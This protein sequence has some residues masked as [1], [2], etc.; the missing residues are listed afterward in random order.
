MAPGKSWHIPYIPVSR[1]LSCAKYLYVVLLQPV[2]D[3]QYTRIKKLLKKV[4]ISWIPDGTHY[5]GP[6][7]L[8]LQKWVRDWW[9]PSPE[10]LLKIAD[11]AY[12]GDS[13]ND[14][15]Y[16][17]LILVDSRWKEGLENAIAA[18]WEY[19]ENG[20]GLN[21]VRVTMNIAEPLIALCEQDEDFTMAKT[22]THEIYQNNKIDLYDGRTRSTE[23][24]A[25]ALIESCGLPGSWPQYL[26]LSKEEL[27][28]VSFRTLAYSEINDLKQDVIDGY[29]G[30]E[31]IPHI[32]ISNWCGRL[33][34]RTEIRRMFYR[35]LLN[36]NEGTRD[37]PLIFVD[38]LLK[39][40]NDKPQ[41]ACARSNTPESP[42][43]F[44]AVSAGMR[45]NYWKEQ[46]FQMVP[47]KKE[48]LIRLWKDAT[49][50][51]IGDNL[52]ANNE[53]VDIWSTEYVFDFNVHK[54]FGECICQ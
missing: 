5:V 9:P 38:A 11:H 26:A 1:G 20:Y 37:I 6:R 8:K 32:E 44:S 10:V 27:L 29:K 39:D 33:P 14:V 30:E 25:P 21:A 34:T 31:K 49:Q 46:Y 50:G 28:I 23:T 24:A 52:V 51:I 19:D 13:G 45:N 53:Y 43:A 22:L 54:N 12:S 18:R 16:R 40:R 2:T 35:I 15:P 42:D 3:A 41:L 17:S 47:V 48:N 7:K 36:S 4:D